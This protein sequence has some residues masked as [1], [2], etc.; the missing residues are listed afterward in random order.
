MEFLTAKGSAKPSANS[1]P[2][3]GRGTGEGDD[4][5]PVDLLL[6]LAK[7]RSGR[8]AIEE[9][10]RQLRLQQ[11][12][13]AQEQRQRQM[14]AGSNGPQISPWGYE[15]PQMPG[16]NVQQPFAANGFRRAPRPL[17]PPPPKRADGTSM[18]VDV[19]YE[20]PE[21]PRHQPEYS[22]QAEMRPSL[23]PVNMPFP[24]QSNPPP[25]AQQGQGMDPIFG[26]QAAP[27]PPPFE[28]EAFD[29]GD[30]G[31]EVPDLPV[32]QGN[33]G[34]FNPFALVQTTAEG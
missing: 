17:Q 14:G 34:H 33:E 20:G 12:R 8:R 18:W 21:F 5:T 22:P 19:P 25:A 1:R 30:L 29:F 4:Q 24:P 10:K 13:E 3:A 16:L 26:D 9:E 2:A 32:N 23:S 27:P 7:T 15:A 31:I 28:V 6:G 11:L